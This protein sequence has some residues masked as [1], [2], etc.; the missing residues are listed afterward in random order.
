MDNKKMAK[1]DVNQIRVI[2]MMLENI[3]H[4]DPIGFLARGLYLSGLEHKNIKDLIGYMSIPISVYDDYYV[5]PSNDSIEEVTDFA[6]KIDIMLFVEYKLS[7]AEIQEWWCKEPNKKYNQTS[8]EKAEHKI[9]NMLKVDE[10]NTE[11]K[12]VF[13]D[14]VNDA[15][16]ISNIGD[17][18]FNNQ[19]L[20]FKSALINKLGE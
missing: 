5:M 12:D 1:L 3:E 20:Y 13:E 2:K 6:A 19:I 16:P 9:I 14:A 17:S 18:I 4:P 10:G 15:H 7:Y 8:L 11:I